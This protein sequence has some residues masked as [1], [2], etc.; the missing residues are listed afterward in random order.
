M[1]TIWY[2]TINAFLFR[3]TSTHLKLNII[4]I[5]YF[6]TANKAFAIFSRFLM[7]YLLNGEK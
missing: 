1:D 4:G 6:I 2:L 3:H 7:F 5:R